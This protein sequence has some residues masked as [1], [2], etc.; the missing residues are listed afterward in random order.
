MNYRMVLKVLGNVLLYEAL[1]LLVPFG[2]ALAYG[3]G[4]SFAFLITIL[5]MMPISILLRR[6][7]VKEKDIYAKEGFLTVGLTW[8]VIS[9]FGAIPFVING[10]I[11]SFIDAFF[12]TVSGFTTTGATL[13]T[14]IQSLPR[15]ILFWRSFTHWIGGM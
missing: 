14:E 4:D 15:G 7:E 11:P 2:I 6:I 12:E 1:L 8:I 10:A 5:L 9:I 13:L 3:D